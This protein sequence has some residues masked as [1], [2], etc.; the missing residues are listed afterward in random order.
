MGTIIGPID[1]NMD[2]D[3]IAP[4]EYCI[5][6]KGVNQAISI[7]EKKQFSANKA[8]HLYGNYYNYS[9]VAIKSG[10]KDTKKINIRLP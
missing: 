4:M 9:K 6:I 3:D 2:L 10:T 5:L 7:N 8:K 1:Y